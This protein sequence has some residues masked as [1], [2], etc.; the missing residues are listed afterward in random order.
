MEGFSGLSPSRW[1]QKLILPPEQ[2][3]YCSAAI[4]DGEFNE[5]LNK[6]KSSEGLCSPTRNG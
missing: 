6:L 1:D 5:D 2:Y 3:A 4:K